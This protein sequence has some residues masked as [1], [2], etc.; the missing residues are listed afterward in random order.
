MEKV[1]EFKDRLIEAFR[2]SRFSQKELASLSNV[3]R[4]LLNMYIKGKCKA[5][6]ENVVS[7]ATVLSV[8]PVWLMGFDVSKDSNT[9][10]SINIKRKIDNYLEEMNEKELTSLLS[11]IETFMKGEKR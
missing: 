4:P 2:E 1:A 7:L 11:F 5:S 3:S 6:N 8:S 9:S 10:V